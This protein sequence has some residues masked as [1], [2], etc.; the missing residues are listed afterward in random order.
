M[1]IGGGNPLSHPQLEDFLTHLKDLKC[2][3]SITVNEK[4]FLDEYERLARLRDSKLIYGLGI[5]ISYMTKDIAE[6]I[7]EFPNAVCHVIAGITSLEQL[8]QMSE[9]GIKK[10]LILGYKIFGRGEKF[11]NNQ[12]KSNIEKLRA[13]MKEVQGLF[14]ILSFDNLAIK[15]LDIKSL[16][17]KEKWEEFYMGDDGS[18]TMY[19]DLVEQKYAQ[20]STSV[21]RFDL[22][23]NINDMFLDIRERKLKND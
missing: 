3:A 19:I 11:Y 8:K 4:H 14:E 22:L 17:S 7:A 1:A 16:M 12:I 10:V 21:E 15:Q 2:I 6:K 18:F 5:S 23:P 9:L 20:S 13:N